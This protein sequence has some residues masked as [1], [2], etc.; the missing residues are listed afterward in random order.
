MAATYAGVSGVNRKMTKIPVGVSGTNRECQSAWAGV[1]SVNRQVFASNDADVNPS[2]ITYGASGPA[3]EE[4][5]PKYVRCSNGILA[6]SFEAYMRDD[7]SEVSDSSICYISIPFTYNASIS[8][9]LSA[10]YG[11][12]WSGSYQVSRTISYGGYRYELLNNTGARIT[13]YYRST[14]NGWSNTS[15]ALMAQWGSSRL[16]APTQTMSIKI[17]IIK[18]SLTFTYT[19][20]TNQLYVYDMP[21]KFNDFERTW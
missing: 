3:D 7:S 15:G 14:N 12:R 18:C 20:D 2:A 11:V 16:L 9:N 19:I 8:P 4:M 6:M 17:N 1:S 21:T 5:R 13:S 10:E